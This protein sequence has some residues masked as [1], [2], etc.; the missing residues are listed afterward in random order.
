M[1]TL[2]DAGIISRESALQELKEYGSISTEAKVGESPNKS[3]TGDN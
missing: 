1:A 3:T 2:T